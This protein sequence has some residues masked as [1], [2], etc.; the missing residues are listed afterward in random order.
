MSLHR[1]ETSWPGTLASRLQGTAPSRQGPECQQWRCL[2]SLPAWAQRHPRSL[3][4]AAQ[5]PLVAGEGTFNE[6]ALQPRGHS[7]VE[8]EAVW[9]DLFQPR[10]CSARPAFL[11]CQPREPVALT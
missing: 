5:L 2:W 7:S 3:V 1:N 4:L 8:G 6:V 10:P 9:Q 11:R